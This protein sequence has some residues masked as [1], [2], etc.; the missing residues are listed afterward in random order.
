MMKVKALLDMHW[1]VSVMGYVAGKNWAQSRISVGND[2]VVWI[3]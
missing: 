1:E 3:T 2:N